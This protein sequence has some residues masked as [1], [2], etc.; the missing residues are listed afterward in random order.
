MHLAIFIKFFFKLVT[1][2]IFFILKFNMS[3]V[4]LIM[5]YHFTAAYWANVVM[6]LKSTVFKV[7]ATRVS[8]L[9]P[10]PVTEEGRCQHN[11][12]CCM[13]SMRL[14]CL[15]T[16]PVKFYFCFLKLSCWV[17]RLLVGFL[18]ALFVCLLG[19]NVK[20]HQHCKVNKFIS[21]LQ[22]SRIASIHVLWSMTQYVLI[23]LC[24]I[25]HHENNGT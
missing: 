11:K 4:K 25:I 23:V 22:N 7:Q 5:K 21:L 13:K 1:I 24:S 18:V 14:N 16:L 12:H 9:A 19:F 15:V 17:F 3:Y 10:L 20:I 6:E 2:I 8:V